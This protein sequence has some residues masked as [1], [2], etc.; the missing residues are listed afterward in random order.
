MTDA[1]RQV[2][3]DPSLHERAPFD[4]IASSGQVPSRYS[5]EGSLSR[6]QMRRLL[7]VVALSALAACDS[8]N[9]LVD[10]TVTGTWR[11]T[12]ASQ[13]FVIVMQQSG[14]I[15]AGS[16]TITAAGTTRNLSVSGTFNQRAFSGTLTP[17]GGQAI[18]MQGTVEGRSFVGT[19]SGGGFNGEGLALTRD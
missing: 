18:T 5:P 19:L 1:H 4:E 7:A 14:T 8:F 17:T 16:G 15:V 9:P 12:A 3:Q 2:G 6:G 10:N 11:G 13:Q